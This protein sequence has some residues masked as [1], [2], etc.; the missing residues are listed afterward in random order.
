[1]LNT[2]THTDS[3]L[4][5][6]IKEGSYSAFEKVFKSYYEA[7]CRFAMGYLG[8]ADLCEEAVQQVFFTYWERRE[9]INIQTSVKSYLYQAVKNNCLNTLKHEQV[10][11]AAQSTIMQDEELNEQAEI[12]QD[13]LI[14]RIENV[15][16]EMPTERQKI[17]RMSRFDE[18]KYREIAEKL[19]ISIK[20][21]ENQMGKALKFLRE[22]LAE[23]VAIFLW[24]LINF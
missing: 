12:E 1:M 7:L 3:Q 16:S 23:V 15:I 8:D 19:S 22:Q 20:T 18:L 10:K 24:M 5:K 13:E 11:L 6:A 2:S 4:I 21:V 9:Q 14:S 17:F